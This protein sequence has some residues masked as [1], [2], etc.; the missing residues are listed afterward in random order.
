MPQILIDEAPTLVWQPWGPCAVQS[1]DGEWSVSWASV[2]GE[3]RYAAWRG[4]ERI[5]GIYN[6]L[7]EAKAAIEAER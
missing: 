4:K 7:D 5:G 3:W 1:S 2:F 6:T